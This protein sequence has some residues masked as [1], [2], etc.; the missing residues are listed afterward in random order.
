MSWWRPTT[1]TTGATAVA[2]VSNVT[3][4]RTGKPLQEVIEELESRV[5]ILEAFLSWDEELRKQ[6]PA[7]QDLYE[8][9]QATKV[10]VNRDAK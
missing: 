10:L 1:T 4:K 2:R 6:H 7:L 5:I 3:A 8:Q 9:F